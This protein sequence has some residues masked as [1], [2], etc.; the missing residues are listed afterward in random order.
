VVN[1]QYVIDA[2]VENVEKALGRR[3]VKIDAE[4]R[5]CFV[6]R[7]DVANRVLQ[8]LGLEQNMFTEKREVRQVEEFSKLSDLELVQL[9][10]QEAKKLLIEDHSG[11]GKDGA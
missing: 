5:E 6:F 8:L 7:G 10:E 1:K 3:P 4:G 2:C 11:G 9:L